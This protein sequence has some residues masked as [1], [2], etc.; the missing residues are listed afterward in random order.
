MR[1][2]AEFSAYIR[3]LLLSRRINA[4]LEGTKNIEV[5]AALSNASKNLTGRAGYPDIVAI[6]KDFILIME[7]KS[8]HFKLEK[9]DGADFSEE[10]DAVKNYAVNGALFYARKVFEGTRYTKIFA[11]GNAGDET[12]HTYKPVFIGEGKDKKNVLKELS[13]VETF[14]DF[15]AENIDN[16]YLQAVCGEELPEAKNMCS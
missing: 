1:T 3:D 13:P 2:E 12:H 7:N 11:F 8:D 10:I 15:T 9:K 14:I 5:D 6:V 16:Y 4:R